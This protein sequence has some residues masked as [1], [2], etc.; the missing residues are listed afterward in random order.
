MNAAENNTA[1]HNATARK[2]AQAER[3][4]PG[5]AERINELRGWLEDRLGTGAQL[6]PL[7]G[8]ASA[9]RY[10]RA[11]A[12][13]GQSAVLMDASA[14]P[15]CIAPFIAAGADLNRG[16]LRT[17]RL[18]DS[19]EKGGL[20]LLEDAGD[21]SFLGTLQELGRTSDELCGT[22]DDPIVIVYRRALDEILTIHQMPCAHLSDYNDALIDKEISLFRDWFLCRE[23]GV[24]HFNTHWNRHWDQLR[25]TLTD[26]ATGQRQVW[27]HRDFHS[28]NLMLTGA[29][30]RPLL[31]DFQDAVRGP[32]CYDVVSL[33]RD[34]YYQ[35]DA[36]QYDFLRTH[37]VAL[38]QSSGNVASDVFERHFD[39][40]AAQR[41]LKVIGIFTRLKHR[42]GKP[43][44]VKDIPRAW[45]YLT[46]VSA[47]YEELAWLNEIITQPP[48]RNWMDQHSPQ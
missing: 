29:D 17:P 9:R 3:S 21:V 43:D 35:L 32:V 48:V 33:L 37:F 39:L 25:K 40:L 7:A 47:R 14:L 42:D 26:N 36:R 24:D 6:T 30:V 41:H 5:Q 1:G 28:R 31:L 8:D 4:R 11:R 2:H 22:V 34:Y 44:Y 13:N 38:A 45:H 16:G 20:L 15:E 23:L 10:Y 27:V 12:D 18:L 46:E 19:D